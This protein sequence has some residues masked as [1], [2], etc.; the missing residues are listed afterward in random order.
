MRMLR[1][2]QPSL[3]GMPT[4]IAPS[5]IAISPLVVN[6]EAPPPS[7]GGV[8]LCAPMCTSDPMDP[9]EPPS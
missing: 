1:R 6:A 9:T 8:S 5:S 3:D 4:R 7:S 2:F